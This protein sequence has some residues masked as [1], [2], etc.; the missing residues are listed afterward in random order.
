MTGNDMARD[1]LAQDA[2][3]WLSWLGNERE[4]CSVI[5]SRLRAA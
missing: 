4:V 1:W 3:P 5:G 2:A